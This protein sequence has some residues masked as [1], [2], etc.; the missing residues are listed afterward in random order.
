MSVNER[1]AFTA[2][3]RFVLA[4]AEALHSENLRRLADEMQL[5]A[6]DVS[7]D[8]AMD[9]VWRGLWGDVSTMTVEEAALIA[10]KFIR[11]EGD[12]GQGDR[13]Y[14][15]VAE[16][17]GSTRSSENSATWERWLASVPHSR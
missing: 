13:G 3:Y 15:L 5:A 12:W 8:P 17:L 10:S 4:S 7:G 14:E 6:G 16:D 2:C 1:Q 9:D 11:Q